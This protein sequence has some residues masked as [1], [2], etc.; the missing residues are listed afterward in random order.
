MTVDDNYI[1]DLIES[2]NGRFFFAFSHNINDLKVNIIKQLVLNTNEITL[3]MMHST[4]R[5]LS[6]YNPYVLPLD[7]RT[8]IIR[9]QII[10]S[11]FNC[12]PELIKMD[13][14]RC[15][16][17]NLINSERWKY[18]SL[19]LDK[20][21]KLSVKYLI[22]N[23][24][25]ILNSNNL[26]NASRNHQKTFSASNVECKETVSRNTNKEMMKQVN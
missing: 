13:E 23:I 19:Y 16:F 7:L 5:H 25:S 11:L 15:L 26:K 24:N 22:E 12:P 17:N 9:L 8:N 1:N 2:C 18:E 10:K 21:Q 6:S 4:T 20:Y 14:I 3:Q